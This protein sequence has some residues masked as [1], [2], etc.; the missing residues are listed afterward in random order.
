M[1]DS[2]NEVSRYIRK[3][4][5]EKYENKCCECGW[6]KINTHTGNIPLTV[7]HIN[8]NSKDNR[9]ENLKLLCPN[10]HSLTATYGSLNR[11]NGREKRRLKI[12]G[13]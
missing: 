1:K 2:G 13:V 8:G 7:E 10:C 5:F 9:E 12:L 6:N 4:L 3:Y 11:G